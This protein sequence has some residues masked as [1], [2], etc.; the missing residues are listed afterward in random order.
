MNYFDL[1]IKCLNQPLMT[2]TLKS[3]VVIFG[4]GGGATVV[5]GA[6]VVVFFGQLR[7]KS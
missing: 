5:V 3:G 6:G 1:S 2:S 7:Q 4:G